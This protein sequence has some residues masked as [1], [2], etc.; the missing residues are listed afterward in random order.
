MIATQVMA[1]TTLKGN[2]L[3]CTPTGDGSACLHDT[4]IKFGRSA[5]GGR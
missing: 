4:I 1:D 3:K 2:F 5:S